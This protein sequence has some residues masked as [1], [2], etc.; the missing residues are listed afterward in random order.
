MDNETLINY[1]KEYV[2]EDMHNYYDWGTIASNIEYIEDLDCYEIPSIDWIF[3][4]NENG[5]LLQAN[6]NY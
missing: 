6:Y 1:A 2:H 3:Y 4:I 5:E